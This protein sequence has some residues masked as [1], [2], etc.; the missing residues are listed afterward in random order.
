MPPPDLT[1]AESVFTKGKDVYDALSSVLSRAFFAWITV[2]LVLM[3]LLFAAP[4]TGTQWW[5][6]LLIVL[7]TAVYMVA[8]KWEDVAKATAAGNA[9]TS[10]T[11][12]P[13][14]PSTP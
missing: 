5:Y 8:Q 4:D 3:S 2:S 6:G 7:L 9:V 1:G 11:E 12:T 10:I 14:T 13:S